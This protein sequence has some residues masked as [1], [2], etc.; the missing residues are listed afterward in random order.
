MSKISL[1]AK[2][3]MIDGKTRMSMEKAKQIA[4]IDRSS[5]CFKGVGSI[6]KK[7]LARSM[8]LSEEKSKEEYI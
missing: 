1:E 5:T 8:W 3:P 6:S 4:H 2:T 7:D